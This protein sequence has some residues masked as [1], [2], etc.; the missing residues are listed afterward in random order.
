[1]FDAY[2]L[3]ISASQGV[4][5]LTAVV[6]VKC[7]DWDRMTERAVRRNVRR[8]I[9]QIWD[10]VESELASDKE[11]CPGVIFRRKPG[12]DPKNETTG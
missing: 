7:S 6:A 1:M 10:Y 5:H 11:P 4:S 8:Q 2:L 9:K 3:A 12:V